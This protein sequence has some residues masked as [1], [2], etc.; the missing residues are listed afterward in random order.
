M[1]VVTF[2]HGSIASRAKGMDRLLPAA[3]LAAAIL[4]VLGLTFPILMVDRFFLFSRPFSI[5]DSLVSLADAGE[6]F[7]FTVIFCFTVVFPVAKLSWA[8]V[9]WGWADVASP[10][11]GRMVEILDTLGK[12]S[13]L[14]VMLL[15]V[16]VASIKLSLV[17]DA[18]ANPGLYLFSGAIILAM[19]GSVWL[20]AAARR[21]RGAV[22][23]GA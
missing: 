8:A 11:F 6:Y 19:M 12:W 10:S 2:S 4:L 15:A 17:G 3:L 13:M 22:P 5:V 14:D 23:G 18:H 16:A 7:L 20:K 21:A 1:G 9:I